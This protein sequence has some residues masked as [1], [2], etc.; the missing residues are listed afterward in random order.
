MNTLA[1]YGYMGPEFEAMTEVGTKVC[2]D[3]LDKTIT[4]PSFSCKKV[5]DNFNNLQ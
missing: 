5:I 2:E 4:E 3:H 1:K